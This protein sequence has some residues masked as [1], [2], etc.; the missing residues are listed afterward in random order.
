VIKKSF[1]HDFLISISL[2]N[3][4]SHEDSFLHLCGTSL[5]TETEVMSMVLVSMSISLKNEIEV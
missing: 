1:K 2:K 4:T 5:K 3:E